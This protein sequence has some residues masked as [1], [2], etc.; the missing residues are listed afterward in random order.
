[1]KETNVKETMEYLSIEW[2][3]TV[4]FIRLP[5]FTFDCVE[6]LPVLIARLHISQKYRCCKA[7]GLN[8]LRDATQR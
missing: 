3:G 8:W 7:I 5:V 4:V 6:E 1:M 2:I